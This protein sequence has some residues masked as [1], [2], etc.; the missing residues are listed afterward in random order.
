MPTSKHYVL[1]PFFMSEKNE[2]ITC[3]DTIRRYNS[4]EL[5]DQYMHKYCDADW[6]ECKFAMKIQ[7]LYDKNDDDK[8]NMENDFLKLKV[9]EQ[10]KEIDSL[11]KK[12]GKC[13]KK[14]SE[15]EEVINK[16]K[17]KKSMIEKHYK[18][19]MKKYE[20]EKRN[21]T[22]ATSKFMALIQVYEARFCYLMIK[23]SN[24]EFD[25]NEFKQWCKDKK[26]KL[27]SI[28]DKSNNV[29]GFKAIVDK[30]KK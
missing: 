1:C 11:S 22:S 26:Y 19:L 3:E 28:K 30:D 21:V 16:L 18:V 5:K 20:N 8:G 7:N 17:D 29:V 14:V 9:K 2:S 23:N 10:A 15:M 24:G 12:L 4:V 13:R 25:E 27:E 6:K